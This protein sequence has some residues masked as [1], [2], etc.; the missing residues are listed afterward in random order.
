MRALAIETATTVCGIA[1]IRD[2]MEPVERVL[3]IPNVHSERL[4]PMISELLTETGIPVNELDCLAV[5]IGPGSFTGLRIGLSVAKGISFAS[6]IPIVPVPTLEA[7]A[8]NVVRAGYTGTEILSLLDAHRGDAYWAAYRLTPERRLMEI[9]RISIAR[10]ESVAEWAH[11]RKSIALVGNMQP[12]VALRPELQRRWH[13]DSSRC[14][15]VSVGQLG[16]LSFQ[17]GE[18]AD[19]SLLEPQYLRDFVPRNNAGI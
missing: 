12:C 11:N 2:G 16:I 1:L 15:P 19:R 18:K 7:L 8:Y 3:D 17:S 5:S 6:D 9:N 13:S 10:Y 4:V 14:S